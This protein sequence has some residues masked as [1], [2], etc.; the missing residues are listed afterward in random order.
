[1][2]G[3]IP[4]H[5][6]LA[7]RPPQLC[8]VMDSAWSISPLSQAAPLL[9][10]IHTGCTGGRQD[11]PRLSPHASA[12]GSLMHLLHTAAASVPQP[13]ART[14]LVSLRSRTEYLSQL[15]FKSPWAC[16]VS[17]GGR[18][19]VSGQAPGSGIHP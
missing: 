19:Q 10:R 3:H 8:T 5:P 1:M 17:S 7:L 11:R 6:K 14:V 15:Q 4:P 13:L 2:P 9:P 18:A 12:S 16:G